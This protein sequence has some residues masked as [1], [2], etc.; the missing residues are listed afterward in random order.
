MDYYGPNSGPIMTDSCNLWPA[1]KIFN[2]ECSI[3]DFSKKNLIYGQMDQFEH[4]MAQKI[5]YPYNSESA[6][7]NIL[8]VS[9]VKGRRVPKG[10]FVSFSE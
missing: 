2:S 1:I 8:K 3:G 5:V 7:R 4:N 10:Y 9:T 6:F